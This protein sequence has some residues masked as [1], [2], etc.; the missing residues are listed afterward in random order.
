M[1]MEAVVLSEEFIRLLFCQITRQKGPEYNNLDI[2]RN[3][4]H[5]SNQELVRKI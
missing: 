1:M 4:D 2:H 3:D 5:K